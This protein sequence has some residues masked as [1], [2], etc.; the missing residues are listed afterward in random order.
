MLI[1]GCTDGIGLAFVESFSKMGFNLILVARNR[2]KLDG[3]LQSLRDKGH[4]NEIITLIADLGSSD[5][6]SQLTRDL[7]NLTN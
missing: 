4:T 6:I 2:D 7:S 5:E 1:T 3:V